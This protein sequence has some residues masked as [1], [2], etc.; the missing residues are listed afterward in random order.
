VQR[1][2]IRRAEEHT[3]HALAR[4]LRREETERR[5]GAAPALE[6][7]E[8]RLG[9]AGVRP[10]PGVALFESR[11]PLHRDPKG[12]LRRKLRGRGRA[13]RQGFDDRVGGGPGEEDPRFRL[14]REGVR[15]DHE[16]GAGPLL[17]DGGRLQEEGVPGSRRGRTTAEILQ[18]VE[19]ARPRTQ[20][21][22]AATDLAP[23]RAP[24][25]ERRRRELH[26]R[27]GR[28]RSARAPHR[29]R[30]DRAPPDPRVSAPAAAFHDR[31]AAAMARRFP[32]LLLRRAQHEIEALRIVESRRDH[33]EGRLG[34]RDADQPR[35]VGPGEEVALLRSR[36][37]HR[38]P[39]AAA[40][41]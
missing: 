15:G 13:R 20:P 8:R 3:E 18:H 12:E 41:F 31:G 32:G 9:S 33:L 6:R 11:K 21:L 24:R 39:F 19:L 10:P 29:Q 4:R 25:R 34:A 17:E 28:R 5:D 38:I 7:G 30:P 40:R 27:R 1:D 23:G 22:L 2:L 35:P 16:I 37:I 36:R 14:A 26:L